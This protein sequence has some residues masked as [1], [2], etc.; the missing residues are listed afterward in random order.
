MQL[1]DE[2][3][4][5]R[6]DIASSDVDELMCEDELDLLRGVAGQQWLRH[7]DR[8]PDQTENGRTDRP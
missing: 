8:R 5:P 4:L 1:R 3:K 7:Q 6:E 2:L